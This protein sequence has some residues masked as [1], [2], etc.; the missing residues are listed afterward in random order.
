M[1]FQAL[2]LFPQKYTD[3]LNYGLQARAH[4]KGLFE[5]Y[6]V[7]LR[8]FC[9]PGRQG[10][11]DDTPYGGGP[12]MVLQVGPIDRA[13]QSL[14]HRFPVIL[15]TPRGVPLNQK[16]VRSFSQMEGLTLVSGYYEGVD[17]RVAEHLVDYEISLGNYILN[18][19][20]LAALCFIDAVTRL[21]PGFMGSP[22]SHAEES[23]EED[24]LLEYPQYTRPAEYR[25]WN[26]P[27]ILLSG[28]HGKIA[29][30]RKQKSIE[31]TENRKNASLNRAFEE[32]ENGRE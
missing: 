20:D 29:A 30:W 25:G 15:F 18:S 2:T 23:H 14:E 26:V 7:H 8:D 27:E 6:P 5:L 24:G 22:D 4:Q 13:L 21:I 9:D 19:G 10:R 32:K 17:D 1:I 28:D 12:G 11:V 3:Y 16:L 31:I